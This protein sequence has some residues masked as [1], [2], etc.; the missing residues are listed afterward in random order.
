MFHRRSVI[1]PLGN[2]QGVSI[3]RSILDEAGLA[4]DSPIEITVDGAAI[5]E[6]ELRR[7]NA[8]I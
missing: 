8:I 3:P 5:V 7:R 4:I 6:A 2:S 1:R